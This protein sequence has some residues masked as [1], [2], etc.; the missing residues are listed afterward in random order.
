MEQPEAPQP[1]SSKG[2]LMKYIMMGGGGLALVLIIAFGIAFFLKPKKAAEPEAS[3]QQ[4]AATESH[5]EVKPPV[6]MSDS[7]AAGTD[8]ADTLDQADPT[9]MDK[10]MDNLAFLDYTPDSSEMTS[11]QTGMSVEDSLKEMNWIKQQKDSLTQWEKTLNDRQKKL[12]RQQQDVDKK[13]LVIEQAES[14]RVT[15]LAKLYDGM[16]SR[17]VARLMTN[18]DDATVIAI[19]PKMKTKNASEVL[20]LLPAQ[21]AARLSKQLITIAEN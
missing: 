7:A 4:S 17:A 5:T 11:D 10:I 3:T 8:T 21:R 9:A 6:P 1:S 14:S 19:L 15:E 12:D 20:Q 2:N 13:I 16:D 18:L